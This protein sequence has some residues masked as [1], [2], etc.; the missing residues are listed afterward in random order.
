[1]AKE[2]YALIDAIRGLTVLSM[3]IF[4]FSYDVFMVYGRDP[5][6]YGRPAV[7]AWQ[8]SI[9]WTFILVSGF[10]WS[11]GRKSNLRRGIALNLLGL[12]I[13]A[14]TAIA[15]PQ[16]TV[17]FGVL[18]FLGCAALLMIPWERGLRRILAPAGL[19]GSFLLFWLCRG[20]PEGFVGVEG[21][22]ELR[23]PEQLYR[24][25]FLAP[26]GFPG[27]DFSSSDFFPVLPW[28]FLF[29]GGYFFQRI[30]MERESWKRLA[31]LR[32]PLL[33]WLGRKSIWIYLIHQPAAMLVCCLLFSQ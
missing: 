4:H 2:R 14:V 9:C 15:L 18:N 3:V 8:Q 5:A 17:R 13:T 16:E 20:I 19:L 1:M 32:V 26:L 11:W 7:C 22:F 28:F 30:F 25:G 21:L 33:D 27:P 6:W 12:L 29:S 24:V 10:V 23:L 31:R